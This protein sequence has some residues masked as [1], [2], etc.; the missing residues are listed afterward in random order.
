MLSN[1]FLQVSLQITNVDI[2]SREKT[3]LQIWTKSPRPNLQ[4]VEFLQLFVAINHDQHPAKQ[5]AYYLPYLL[6]DV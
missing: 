2:G 1:T 5:H 4:V 6:V 3:G